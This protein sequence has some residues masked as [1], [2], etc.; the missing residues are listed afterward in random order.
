MNGLDKLR[1]RLRDML[2][3]RTRL[4]VV[5]Q[6]SAEEVLPLFLVGT[7][8]S[9]TTLFRYPLDSHSQLCCPPE[10]KFLEHLAAMHDDRSVDKAFDS[11]G[12]D[13]VFVRGQMRFFAN[14]IYGAYTKGMDKKFIVD[15]TPD[16]VRCLEFI[17]WLYEGN[18]RYIMIFRNGLDVAHSMN[19]MHIKPLE[20]DKS[21]NSAF[22]YWKKDTEIMMAWLAANPSRCHKVV[23]DQLCDD[24][25]RVL[26][27]VM[28]FVGLEFEEGQL[29]WYEHE[30]SRGDEDIKA[31]R[32]R[33]INK[34]V[35][36]YLI[37][38]EATIRDLKLRSAQIHG[39]LGFDPDTLEFLSG[40]Q[41]P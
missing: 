16:Y 21:V 29:K 28:D 6:E 11:M 20:N 34:S 8:R 26:Q 1:T 35:H 31:R 2:F 38:P 15:K 18:C 33:K 5:H 10:T 37:W 24:T 7:F 27:G 3:G 39:E 25:P 19:E 14:S 4:K 40:H 30:H 13:E 9:G 32:Q 22:Q 36:N 41:S 12:F 23:Y 17:D